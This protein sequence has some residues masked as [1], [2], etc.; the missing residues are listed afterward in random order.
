MRARLQCA[1]LDLLLCPPVDGIKILNF[2]EVKEI[3]QRIEPFREKAKRQ[4]SELVE[5]KIVH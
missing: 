5:R 1:T 4:I 2:F 3:L